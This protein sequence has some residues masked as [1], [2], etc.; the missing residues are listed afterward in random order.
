MKGLI[1]CSGLRPCG[2]GFISTCK[3]IVPLLVIVFAVCISIREVLLNDPYPWPQLMISSEGCKESQF[4][5]LPFGQVSASMT[6]PRVF[7]TS[8]KNVFHRQHWL[9]SFCNLNFPKNFTRPSGKLRTEFT[10]TI[11]I[12]TS[13]GYRTQ[14][15]FHAAQPMFRFMLVDQAWSHLLVRPRFSSSCSVLTAY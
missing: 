2:H 10:S 3:C 9:Q 15:S 12:S 6:S 4:Y 14:L 11:A 5:G 7:L 1:I 8:P 13:P